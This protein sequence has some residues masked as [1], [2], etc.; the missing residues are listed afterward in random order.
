MALTFYWV[1]KSVSSSPRPTNAAYKQETATDATLG[2][3]SALAGKEEW[4]RVCGYAC[5][6]F[7]LSMHDS[8]SVLE[9]KI[10]GC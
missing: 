8:A 6:H 2:F 3:M 7:H 1:P 5:L 4:V 10:L 9:F